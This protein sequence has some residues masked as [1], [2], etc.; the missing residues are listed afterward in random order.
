M[1]PLVAQEVKCWSIDLA[2]PDSRPDV[3][4]NLF[5]FKRG[6]SHIISVTS[7]SYDVPNLLFMLC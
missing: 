2:F 5:S 1:G 7:V 3:G 4:G 6:S